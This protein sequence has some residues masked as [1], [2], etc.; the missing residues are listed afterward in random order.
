[1][2]SSSQIFALMILF[3]AAGLG[4]VS[5]GVLCNH[6]GI[7]ALGAGMLGSVLGY[8]IRDRQDGYGS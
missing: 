7:F 6:E 2:F 8:V 4:L 3:T 1:M 5:L